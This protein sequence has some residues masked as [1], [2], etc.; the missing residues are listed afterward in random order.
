MQKKRKKNRNKKEEEK[1][2]QS[3]IVVGYR[4]KQ[5]WKWVT[6]ES[7][8]V[9][10]VYMGMLIKKYV[11]FNTIFHCE[12]NYLMLY[13]LIHILYGLDNKATMK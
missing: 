8:A 5:C 10:P 13:H 1:E 11:C 6:Q 9:S 12:K 2:K 4:K 7:D 3:I